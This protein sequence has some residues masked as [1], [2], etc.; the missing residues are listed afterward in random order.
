MVP[1]TATGLFSAM[2]AA[3]PSPAA[4]AAALLSCTSL[5]KP[6]RSASAASKNRAD[7]HTSLTHEELPT[8]LGS[9]DS[10][11]MSAASPMSTSL[12]ARRVSAAQSR[13]SAQQDRSMARPM[14]I[15]WRMQITAVGVHEQRL[16][17][18]F[19]PPDTSSVP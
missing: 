7:R 16:S 18:S 13:T 6:C 9:R 2:R 1:W 12:T 5:T 8:A 10:V 17:L 4:T 11:P 14:D 3:L 19:C 15:P